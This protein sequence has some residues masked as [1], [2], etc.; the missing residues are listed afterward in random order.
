MKWAAIASVISSSAVSECKRAPQEISGIFDMKVSAAVVDECADASV[1]LG[2][3]IELVASE[4]RQNTA[5]KDIC[6]KLV[7]TGRWLLG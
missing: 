6:R 7:E 5:T 4:E 1:R 2:E 3:L